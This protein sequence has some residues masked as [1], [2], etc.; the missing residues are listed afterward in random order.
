[1]FQ[2]RP[3]LSAD[4]LRVLSRLLAI[5]PARRPLCQV[6]AA[7]QLHLLL[8]RGHGFVRRLL[9]SFMAL[10]LRREPA[11]RAPLP[12]ARARET[13][14]QSPLRRPKG[15]CAWSA[16]PSSQAT[17]DCSISAS[18]P[19]TGAR[20]SSPAAFSKYTRDHVLSA[21]PPATR[22]CALRTVHLRQD[23]ENR[24]LRASPRSTGART[25]SAVALS[26]ITEAHALAPLRRR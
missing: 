2:A 8:R 13:A 11:P 20:S 3:A 24:A 18:P 1:M 7:T 10:C 9:Q 22:A 15:V 14:H 26:Q 21:A 5:R 19:A 6:D 4:L 12:P 25:S 17:S 16:F 23:T